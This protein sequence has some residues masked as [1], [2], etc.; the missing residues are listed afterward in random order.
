MPI[1]TMNVIKFME[2]KTYESVLYIY[3]YVYI[4]I[5]VESERMFIKLRQNDVTEY[6]RMQNLD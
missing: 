5:K 1:R 2:N 4:Y 3:I 6:Y